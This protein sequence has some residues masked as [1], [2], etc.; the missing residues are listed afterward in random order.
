MVDVDVQHPPVRRV[1]RE[2]PGVPVALAEQVREAHQLDEQLVLR[3][4]RRTGGQVVGRFLE[5][6]LG[7]GGDR[8]WVDLPD[9]LHQRA[10]VVGRAGRRRVRAQGRTGCDGLGRCETEEQD[11]VHAADFTNTKINLPRLTS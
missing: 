7:G 9:A 4:R 6:G 1:E 5:G 2:D 10:D 8:V 3:E 11:P